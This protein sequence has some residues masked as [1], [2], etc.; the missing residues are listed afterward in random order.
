MTT[1]QIHK[2]QSLARVFRT[3]HADL[4]E[5]ARHFPEISPEG[6]KMSAMVT[7]ASSAA[8]FCEEMAGEREG[9]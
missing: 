6:Q 1:E 4:S 8:F 9:A 2:L 5:I 3:M 7:L